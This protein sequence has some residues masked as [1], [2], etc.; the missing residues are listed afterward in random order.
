MM[1]QR[2]FNEL[3]KEEKHHASKQRFSYLEQSKR[4]IEFPL[5]W[6]FSNVVTPYLQNYENLLLMGNDIKE[7]LEDVPSLLKITVAQEGTST[8]NDDSFDVILNKHELLDA[9]EILRLLM[10]DGYFITEQVGGLNHCELNLWLNVEATESAIHS[11]RRTVN[12][13]KEAGLTILEAKDDISLTRFYDVGAIVYY[14]KVNQWQFPNFTV[15]RYFDRLVAI[16]AMIEQQGYIDITR[17]RFLIVAQKTV[18]N[19]E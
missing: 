3:I 18:F 12:Q 14:L 1:N 7:E 9:K 2:L 5:K 4:M 17:H 8:Y 16:Q 15:E 19:E 11:L 13:L 10:E 6:K